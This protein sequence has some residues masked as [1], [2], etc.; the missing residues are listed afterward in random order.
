MHTYNTSAPLGTPTL[1]LRVMNIGVVLAIL[2]GA[3]GRHVLRA[4]VSCAVRQE[5]KASGRAAM[6]VGFVSTRSRLRSAT[7]S[8]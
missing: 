6:M 2:R 3:Q 4:I 8:R 7:Q 1:P 5:A